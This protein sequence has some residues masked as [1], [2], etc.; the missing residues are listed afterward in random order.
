MPQFSIG[1]VA[2]VRSEDGYAALVLA[3]SATVW[4]HQFVVARVLD[5][6]GNSV[7]DDQYTLSTEDGAT[8][9]GGITEWT[10]KADTLTLW[11]S[12]G[13]ADALALLSPVSLILQVDEVMAARVQRAMAWLIEPST[14]VPDE[15]FDSSPS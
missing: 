4:G 11:L 5:D 2:A 12:G 13:A 10:M 3:E 8:S 15:I 6:S 9:N 1:A 7:A 14:P